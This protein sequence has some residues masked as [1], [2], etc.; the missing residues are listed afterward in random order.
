MKYLDE[1][2]FSYRW[3]DSNTI[4]NH[5]KMVGYTNKTLEYEE[6]LVNSLNRT[7]DIN[8]IVFEIHKYGYLYKKQ[9]IPFVF[10]ILSYK[11]FSKKTRLIK[12]FNLMIF[13]YTK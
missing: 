8:S 11:K 5:E 2:L 4:K 12:L 3:H 13:R 1:V 9:G 7:K 10:Q 6:K